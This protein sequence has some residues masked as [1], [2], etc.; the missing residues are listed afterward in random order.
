M[1]ILSHCFYAF[2]AGNVHLRCFLED[3]TA[4]L[5]L[6]ILYKGST[7]SLGVR[8]TISAESYSVCYLFV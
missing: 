7:T 5:A 4:L 8:T 6:Y 2:L 1:N 3:E